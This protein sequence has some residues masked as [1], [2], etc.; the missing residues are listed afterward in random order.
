MKTKARLTDEP[1]AAPAATLSKHTTLEGILDHLP[2]IVFQLTCGQINEPA[3]ISF[4]SSRAKDLLGLEPEALVLDPALFFN[5]IAPEAEKR[6]RRDL[7]HALM[8]QR[9]WTDV[10]EW[11][12]T[13]K[14]VWLEGHANVREDA[15]VRH[16]DGYLVD[17]TR[18]VRAE[19]ERR[20]EAR[21]GSVGAGR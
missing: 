5:G 9:E 6:M 20:R 14:S 19:A 3:S 11:R 4:V 21:A 10:F 2:C 8:G 7:M 17:V 15:G 16:I 12:G 18:R 1:S 13:R